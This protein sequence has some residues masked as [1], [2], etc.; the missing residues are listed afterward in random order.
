MPRLS[1]GHVGGGQRPGA[2]ARRRPASGANPVAMPSVRDLGD[3][4]LVAAFLT[5]CVARNL[6][7]NTIAAY[8]WAL[9]KLPSTHAPERLERV[10]AALTISEQSRHDLWRVWRTYFRWRLRRHKLPDPME[11][12]EPPARRRRHPRGL[13]PEQVMRVLN[14]VK[15]RRDRALILLLLDT[16]LRIGE[17]AGMQPEDIGRDTVRVS[18]KTGDHEVPISPAVA[19]MVRP[20]LPWEGSYDSLRMACVRALRRAGITKGGPHLFRHTFARH[21][22]LGGG[23]IASLQVILGHADRDSTWVYTELHFEAVKAQHARF[24]PARALLQPQEAVS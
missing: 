4:G 18:S 3:S 13:S 14:G 9:D 6:S 5:S 7:P 2:S 8:R 17:V 24:S 11:A 20:Q 12:L 21:Y 15:L 23:D 1:D 16:G 19:A 22:L 10:M